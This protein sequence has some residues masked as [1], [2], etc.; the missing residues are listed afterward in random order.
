VREEL[1]RLSASSRTIIQ[2]RMSGNEL[3]EIAAET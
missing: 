3:A 1:D 2:F